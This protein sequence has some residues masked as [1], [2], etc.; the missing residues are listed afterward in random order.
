MY[1][2]LLHQGDVF[3]ASATAFNIP[4]YLNAQHNVNIV[5]RMTNEFKNLML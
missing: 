2:T 5:M 4:I 3:Y 1:S